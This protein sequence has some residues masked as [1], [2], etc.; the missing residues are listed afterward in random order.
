[1]KLVYGASAL[2]VVVLMAGCDQTEQLRQTGIDEYKVGH[3]DRAQE[4][5]QRVLA[6]NPSDPYSL[7]YMGRI[8]QTQGLYVKAFSYYQDAIESDPGF[9]YA[10]AARR[11]MKECEQALGDLAPMLL[12]IPKLPDHPLP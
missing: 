6:Q 7:F 9:A 10:P 4:M 5:F 2:L 3:H 11:D 12:T 8:R 1:M